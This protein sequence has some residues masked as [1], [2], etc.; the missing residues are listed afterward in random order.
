MKAPEGG[1]PPLFSIVSSSVTEEWQG[2]I[3]N[4]CV[5]ILLYK[6]E[7]CLGPLFR[8]KRGIELA[9]SQV[10]LYLCNIYQ[11]GGYREKVKR[12]F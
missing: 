12:M 9:E 5:D 1:I 2:E 7:A 6:K 11:E 10:Y 3:G 4:A 8:R